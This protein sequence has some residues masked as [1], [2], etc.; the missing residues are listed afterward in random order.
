MKYEIYKPPIGT[1][2]SVYKSSSLWELLYL[3]ITDSGIEKANG[4]IGLGF[5]IPSFLAYISFR[6]VFNKDS[7]F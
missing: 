3:L 6:P 1:Y 2:S 4:D 7:L 5:E